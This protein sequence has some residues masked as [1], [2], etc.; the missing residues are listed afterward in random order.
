MSDDVFVL[1]SDGY[2]NKSKESYS[3]PLIK[4]LTKL[5]YNPFVINIVEDSNALIK[6]PVGKPI[7]IADSTTNI[8]TEEKWLETTKTY[9]K[10]VLKSNGRGQG[11]NPLL[12]ICFGAQ[13]LSEIIRTGS[14]TNTAT[15]QLENKKIEIIKNGILLQGVENYFNAYTTEDVII[16][17]DMVD[18]TSINNEIIYSFEVRHTS[19]FGVQFHPELN[20]E[21]YRELLKY[22]QKNEIIKYE[23]VKQREIENINKKV[24]MNFLQSEV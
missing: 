15:N 12:G 2:I 21:E 20:Y 3:T 13:L 24:L 17:N 5:G 14:I 8:K 4:R 22:T 18:I 6:I 11:T 23:N 7:I 1:E 9:L 16:D 19:C 10:E